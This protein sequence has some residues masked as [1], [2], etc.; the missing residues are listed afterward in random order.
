MR[1]EWQ[2]CSASPKN[3]FWELVVLLLAASSLCINHSIHITHNTW[4]ELVIFYKFYGTFPCRSI[5][6]YDCLPLTAN[7][8]SNNIILHLDNISLSPQLPP[9]Y[10][11]KIPSPPFMLYQIAHQWL[12]PN[13]VSSYPI[14][15][16]SVWTPQRS[17]VAV[18]SACNATAFPQA[19]CI[20]S[21]ITYHVQIYP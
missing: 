19:P 14:Q 6:W 17:A 3:K 2:Q 10:N 4:K 16:S 20:P 9:P 5:L 15:H 21:P 18:V 7:Q 12:L 1:I 13:Q 11:T 8:S